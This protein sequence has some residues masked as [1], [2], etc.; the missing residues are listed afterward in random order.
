MLIGDDVFVRGVRLGV[1]QGEYVYRRGDLLLGPGDPS[2]EIVIDEQSVIF[3][4]AF[5]RNRAVWPRPVP[6][7][8]ETG[9]VGQAS[10]GSEGGGSS[11]TQTRG[12][13]KT[14]VATNDRT[15]TNLLL[16]RCRRKACSRTR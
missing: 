5:A 15:V 6:K 8:A 4:M 12:V 2:A 14:R 13:N 9:H 10:G 7:A 11:V 1:E 16:T 3:T